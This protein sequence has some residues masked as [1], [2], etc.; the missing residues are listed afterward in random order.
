MREIRKS[1][2]S[3]WSMQ[4][5]IRA[6]L[7]NCIFKICSSKE[8]RHC[9]LLKRHSEG[10]SR[11]KSNMKFPRNP[12]QNRG[13]T[14]IYACGDSSTLPYLFYCWKSVRNDAICFWVI[15]LCLFI[16]LSSPLL[17]YF[18]LCHHG[19][20]ELCVRPVLTGEANT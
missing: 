15:N 4:S 16:R 10:N 19:R 7:I 9:G 14:G 2:S 12:R 5:C 11:E 18:V 6:V 13:L 20:G 17:F 8:Y 1:Y 3:W